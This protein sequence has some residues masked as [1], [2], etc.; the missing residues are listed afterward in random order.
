MIVRSAY[1]LG[2]ISTQQFEASD[3]GVLCVRGIVRSNARD[4]KLI[5]GKASENAHVQ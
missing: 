3:A 2:A 5:G 1:I 4:G